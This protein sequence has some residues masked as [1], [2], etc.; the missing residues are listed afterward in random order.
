MSKMSELSIELQENPVRSAPA[1]AYKP[2]LG[3]LP[4]DTWPDYW[5]LCLA[6]VDAAGDLASKDKMLMNFRDKS[7]AFN[8]KPVIDKYYNGDVNQLKLAR[9]E[10]TKNFFKAI[11]SINWFARQN[12]LNQVSAMKL[13]GILEDEKNRGKFRRHIKRHLEDNHPPFELDELPNRDFR[14]PR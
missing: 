7:K 1:E 9:D 4:V 12:N 8:V 3:P 13:M 10:A 2:A 6:A 11:D 5:R 14:Q